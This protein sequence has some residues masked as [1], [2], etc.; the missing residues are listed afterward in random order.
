V[1]LQKEKEKEGRTKGTVA[2]LC[3]TALSQA[4]GC[5]RGPKSRQSSR[6]IPLPAVPPVCTE[7][8]GAVRVQKNSDVGKKEKVFLMGLTR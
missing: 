5:D 6:W 8:S 3:R 4:G 7:H 1:E 2:P